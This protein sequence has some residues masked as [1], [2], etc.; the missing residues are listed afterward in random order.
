MLQFSAYILPWTFKHFT[1]NVTQMGG[2][3]VIPHYYNLY[4]A[5]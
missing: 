4:E 1:Q 5:N 3:E 2:D